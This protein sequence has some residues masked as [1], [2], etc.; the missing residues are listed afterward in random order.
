MGALTMR[1]SLSV[2]Y[3]TTFHL[4]PQA[5]CGSPEGHVRPRQPLTVPQPSTTR[6]P[7]RAVVPRI[8]NRQKKCGDVEPVASRCHPSRRRCPLPVPPAGPPVPPGGPPVPVPPPRGPPLPA[9][10]PATP[11]SP[12]RRRRCLLPVSPAAA[13]CCPCHPP[14]LP[15]ARARCLLPA[16]PVR[17]CLL[18]APLA[19]NK[20]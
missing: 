16:P 17:R 18:R 4:H 7:V 13:A 1:A 2:R 20:M 14:P 5:M 9:P 12:A 10:S 8:Q 3:P 15:A 11:L 19:T 6:C